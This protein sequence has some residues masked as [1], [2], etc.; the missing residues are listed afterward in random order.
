MN[1]D[2][3]YFSRFE[4]TDDFKKEY[5]RVV[6][7]STIVIYDN[8]FTQIYKNLESHLHSSI[9]TTQL[10]ADLELIKYKFVIGDYKDFEM[11]NKIRLA[12]LDFF[13]R[14]YS[15]IFNYLLDKKLISNVLSIDVFKKLY[16]DEI[17]IINTEMKIL[18]KFLKD[19]LLY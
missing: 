16:A 14:L 12:I 7:N 1:Y 2:S 9:S 15:H 4:L 19:F 17:L 18:L 13:F 3:E 11:F 8:S 5:T 6:Y 10:I